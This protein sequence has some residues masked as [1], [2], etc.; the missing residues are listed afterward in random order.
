MKLFKWHL[1]DDIEL[2]CFENGLIK[3]LKQRLDISE[4]DN[5]DKYLKIEKLEK[6]LLWYKNHQ[7]IEVVNVDNIGASKSKII[8]YDTLGSDKE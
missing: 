4:K 1:I 6:E 3:E 2:R 5:W 7:K 8:Y